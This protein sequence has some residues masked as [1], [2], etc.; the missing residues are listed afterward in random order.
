MNQEVTD[1][2]N[3]YSGEQKAILTKLRTLV[4]S[5]VERAVES[6]K[7]SRPVFSRGKDFAYLKANK[8]D[9][10]L[11]FFN[12][13]KIDDMQGILQGTGKDMRHIKFSQ[14]TDINEDLLSAWL[15]AVAR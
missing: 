1:Y 2:I 5:S 15:Q 11:G 4:H 9:I 12:F 7:W 13:H 6:F 14:T 10:T 3:S 8:K